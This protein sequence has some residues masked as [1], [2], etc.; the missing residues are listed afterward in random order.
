MNVKKFIAANPREALRKVK[1]TLGN[2]AI[3][4]SNRGIPGGVE[5]MA[6]AARDMAMIAPVQVAPE[7]APA[8]AADRRAEP[9]PADEDYRVLLT[10]ARAR[11]AKPPRITEAPPPLGRG[12]PLGA[13]KNAAA[14]PVNAGI[15]R[16][17][18][19]RHTEIGRQTA[20]TAGAR[21]TM[22]PSPLPRQVESPAPVE[23][24]VVPVEVM[25]EIRTL[26]RI[27]E[28]HLAGFAWGETARSEPVKTEILPKCGLTWI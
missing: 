12:V 19:L 26:R 24:E 22:A 1:E 16:T 21:P 2:D 4:L 7:S 20:S 5:I 10:S 28:Q 23:A 11:A 8:S 14:V 6:V 15:P 3:I 27:V 13:P 18:A 9:L 17:G 25:D